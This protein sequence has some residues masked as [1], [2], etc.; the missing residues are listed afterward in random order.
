MRFELY[1]K[2][3][4]RAGVE[5]TPIYAIGDPMYRF[6]ERSERHSRLMRNAEQLKAVVLVRRRQNVPAGHAF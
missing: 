3:G 5:Q 4:Q 2:Y 1:L 6:K